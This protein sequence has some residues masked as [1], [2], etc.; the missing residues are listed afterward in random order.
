MTGDRGWS[1]ST[2]IKLFVSI[3]GAPNDPPALPIQTPN[4]FVHFL[5]RCADNIQEMFRGFF[6]HVRSAI[7]IGAGCIGTPLVLADYK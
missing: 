1:Q 4:N 5:V 7:S 6:F 3:I 2:E